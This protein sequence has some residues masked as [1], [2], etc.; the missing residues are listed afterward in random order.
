MKSK[1]NF[2][3]EELE[4][5]GELVLNTSGAQKKAVRDLTL[6]EGIRLDGRKQ[7]DIRPGFGVK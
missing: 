5:K 4:E 3:E 1:L 6:N 7:T 2:T